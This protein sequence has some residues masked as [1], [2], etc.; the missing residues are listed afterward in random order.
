MSISPYA[1]KAE[2]EW[3]G[4]TQNLVAK[5][6]LQPSVLLDA[7]LTS[8]GTLWQ[9]AVGA[10]E[11]AVKLSDLKVP[12]TIVGYFFEILLARELERRNPLWRG[13]QTKDEKDLVYISDPSLSVEI[14]ASGQA[15][16]KVFGNRSYGQKPESDTA[17]KKEKSGY[18]ITVNFYQQTLT[19]IRF[20]WIDADDWDAQEAPTGQM[21]G[22]RKAVY[23]YKLIS[24]RG[25][26]QQQ[27]PIHL[28]D[29]VGPAIALQFG[30]LGIRTIGDLSRYS[31]K[32]P[33]RLERILKRNQS[34]LGISTDEPTV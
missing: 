16:F 25:P 21:A 24:I 28:L 30:D 12:A 34:F 4:I 33:R 1:G 27:T 32:L 26:Y 29:G 5:H 20:G 8:W 22:L 14:K 15:G 7:S 10:G 2:T 6:P 13:N 18:Y 19:L 23:D 9:T 17:T 31:D 11:L 3:L